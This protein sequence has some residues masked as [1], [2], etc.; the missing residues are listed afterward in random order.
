LTD[1]FILAASSP[2]AS[3]EAFLIGGPEIPSLNDIVFTLASMNGHADVGNV[4]RIPAKPVWLAG[5]LCEAMCRPFRVDPP[6]HRRRVEFFMNNRAYNIEK[7]RTVLGYSPK[8]GLE[9]GLRRTAEWYRT[10]GLL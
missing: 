10:Q 4:I 6:L 2:A 5:W 1:A 7:A 3:G 9:D 8:V